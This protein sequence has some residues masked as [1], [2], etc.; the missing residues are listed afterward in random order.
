MAANEQKL[1]LLESQRELFFQRIHIIYDYS[2]CDLKDPEALDNFL[3]SVESLE[4]LR[5]NFQSAA[6]EY[7]VTLLKIDKENVPDSE[8]WL[9]FEEMYCRIKRKLSMFT[10]PKV[11]FKPTSDKS[12]IR[13]A[14][15]EIPEFNGDRL[16]WPMFYSTFHNAVHLNA[17]LTNTERM[18]YLIGKLSGKA[19]SIC[20][21]IVPCAENYNAIYSALTSRYEDKRSLA[22]TY[23]DQMFSLKPIASATAS[24][25]ESFIDQFANAYL[26]LNNLNIPNLCEFVMS[27]TIL[28]KLDKESARLFEMENRGEEIPDLN[29]LISFV[30]DRVKVL[31]R[32]GDQ[33]SSKTQNTIAS[34]TNVRSFVVF[35]NTAE[36]CSLCQQ[37]EHNNLY[38]CLH[39]KKLS[40]RER[41]NFIKSCNACI[42]CLSRKHTA[43]SCKSVNTCKQ[44]Q[45]KH[46]SMLHFHE[47]NYTNPHTLSSK[48][49]TNTSRCSEGA[50]GKEISHNLTSSKSDDKILSLCSMNTYSHA[51]HERKSQNVLLGT[52]LADVKSKDGS[53]RKV[54]FLIDNGSQN[55]FITKQACKQ[56]GLRVFNDC[57][58]Q[59]VMG[60]GNTSQPISGITDLTLYSRLDPNFSLKIQPLVIETISGDLP[61]C[62]LDTSAVTHLRDL[63]LADP[64]FSAPGPIDILLGSEVFVEILRPGKSLGP[65]GQPDALETAFG[66]I[67]MGSTTSIPADNHKTAHKQ[68]N[69]AF[70]TSSDESIDALVTKFLQLE[71]KWNTKSNPVTKGTVVI[72]KTENSPPLQWPLGI[73][74]DIHPSSD[75]IVR[76]VTVRTKNGTYVLPVVKLC[77][78]PSQ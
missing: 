4:D 13:L 63:P 16:H 68:T 18:Y 69:R 7:N 58:N 34:K 47:S 52:A 12:L 25:L 71:S 73:V 53:V 30:R 75:G 64:H 67:V 9:S 6:K 72:L 44:C 15:I 70:L 5:T 29:G 24:N 33:S 49:D 41:F 8:S 14:P 3:C 17:S 54:R 62:S 37:P 10:P 65:A 32:T 56:L 2:C 46:H 45:Q 60:I 50:S 66:Y 36:K 21:G 61:S 31:T 27:Y 11:E 77:V 57:S 42:N 48:L 38:S 78:L 39:F 40:P 51:S 43:Q 22:V 28:Q 20:T 19:K 55:H 74:E 35:N 76:V 23:L 1:K 26:A 59:S